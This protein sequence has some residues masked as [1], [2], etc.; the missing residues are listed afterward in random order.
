MEL[1]GIGMSS[2]KDEA[3]FIKNVCQRFS[4]TPT[5]IHDKLT[6]DCVAG[7]FDSPLC[8]GIKSLFRY[9]CLCGPLV[10]PSQQSNHYLFTKLF[11]N[12]IA[13]PK[14]IE[15]LTCALKNYDYSDRCSLVWIGDY[16]AYRC[17]TCGLTP[18]MSL[19][20]ACFTAGNHENHDFNKFK[21]MCGGA[22]DCG[23]PS[24]IRPS[25]NCRFH[26]PDKVANRPC[27]PKELIA[28]LEFLLPDVM[29]ALMFWFWDHCKVEEPALNESEA[30][31]LYFLHRLHACGWVTQQ[32]MVDVMIDPQ[33]YQE[34]MR[35]CACTPA[36]RSYKASVASKP[37]FSLRDDEDDDGAQDLEHTTLLESFLFMIRRFIDAYVDHYSR[38]SST[39]MIT[40]RVRNISPEAAMQLNNRIV[41]ISVQL[42]S[43]VDHAYRMVKEKS[44]HY[45]IVKWMRNMFA[46]SR[47]RLDDRGNMV[48]NCDGVLIQ[49]NAFWPLTSD[50]SNILSHKVVAD[51]LVEDKKFLSLWTD[52]LKFM[53][54]MNCFSM[55]EGSHIEYETMAC[56][57]GLTME[58]EVS[59]SIMWYIWDHYRTPPEKEH[60][61]MYTRACIEALAHQLTYLGRLVASSTQ[62]AHPIRGPLS[63]HLPLS[64]HAACFL[65]LAVF[66]HHADVREL[67]MPFLVPNP[68]VLRRLMEEL[69]NVLLG[70]HE[71][72]IGYW[73]RNGQP[74][75]Q[76]VL[77]YMQSQMCY[78]M[79][80]LDIFLF[81]VCA[82]LMH[83]VYI[84]N[85]LV[86]QSRLL[87]NFCFHRELMALTRPSLMSI[88]VDRQPMA[89]EAWLTNLCWVL[90]LRNNLG[91][92]ETGLIE[93][94]LVCFLAPE[95]R[96]RSDLSYLLPDRCLPQNTDVIDECLQ[97]VATYVAPSCDNMSGSLLS[98]HYSLKPELWHEK[99]DPVFYTLRM[100]SKREQASALEKY[101]LHCR[102]TGGAQNT[103]AFWPPYRLP[104]DLVPDFADLENVLHSRHLHYLLFSLLSLAWNETVPV[105]E[106]CRGKLIVAAFQSVTFDRAKPV[107]NEATAVYVYG[108][109]LMTEES[110]V[111]VIHLLYRAVVAG[112]VIL[113]EGL[114]SNR[115]NVEAEPTMPKFDPIQC[116]EAVMAATNRE[117]ELEAM[118]FVDA[119]SEVEDL[120]E[121]DDDELE[122]AGEE[123]E[124]ANNAFVGEP[125]EVDEPLVVPSSTSSSH[126]STTAIR[127][128][129][130]RRSNAFRVRRPPTIP[131]KWDLSIVACPYPVPQS[132]PTI[133]QHLP[134]WLATSQQTVSVAAL[135]SKFL[136]DG[137]EYSSPVRDESCPMVDSLLSLLVK[138]HARLQWSHMATTTDPQAQQA[139]APSCTSVAAV[140]QDC[141]FL[142]FP[143]SS[144]PQANAASDTSTPIADLTARCMAV[145]NATNTE[146]SAEGGSVISPLARALQADTSSNTPEAKMVK[147]LTEMPP[148]LR[149]FAVAPP[150]Y[151]IPEGEEQ[152]E[153]AEKGT[154]S[155]TRL[156]TTGAS[157]VT[158]NAKPVEC[159]DGVF[160]V[161]RLLDK[162]MEI[163]PDCRTHLKAFLDRAN[164]PFGMHQ[165]TET[166]GEEAESALL[167]SGL[168]SNTKTRAQRKRAASERRKRLLDLMASK[169]RA[170]ADN[171]LKYIDMDKIGDEASENLEAKMECEYDCVI[172]QAIPETPQPMVLL[173]MLCES[174]LMER[175]RNY[176]NL[177]RLSGERM[178]YSRSYLCEDACVPR[179]L[180]IVPPE[181]SRLMDV[182]PNRQVASTPCAA[183]AGSCVASAACRITDTII[184]PPSTLSSTPSCEAS[185]GD[186]LEP[187]A[188]VEDRR[189][190][191]LALPPGIASSL[192][193]LRS[194]ALLQTCGHAVHRECFQRYRLQSMH[195]G[196][197]GVTR[198]LVSCPLC[199]RDVH[200][201]LPLHRNYDPER[202]EF[203][204]PLQLKALPE[205]NP[206]EGA[207]VA[208]TEKTS[209]VAAEVVP[210]AAETS[211]QQPTASLKI[212]GA[213]A[214]WPLPPPPLVSPKRF[215]Q[216]LRERLAALPA[217]PHSFWTNLVGAG[218]DDPHSRYSLMATLFGDC[219]EVSILLRS[220]FEAEL[221]VLMV[222][223]TL[224][225]GVARRC[226]FRELLNYLRHVYRS[227][228]DLLSL[229]DSLALRS[230][231]DSKPI[232]FTNS[233]ILLTFAI[234]NDP[235]DVLMTLLP[236]VW[237]NEEHFLAL[238]SACICLAYARALV[239]LILGQMPTGNSGSYVYSQRTSI[240]C[241]QER[242]KNVRI[243][244]SLSPL[245]GCV[246]QVYTAYRIPS[247]LKSNVL[248]M[249][250]YL[251][252]MVNRTSP[253]GE[254]A[255]SAFQLDTATSSA[256]ST[257]ESVPTDIEIAASLDVVQLN[258]PPQEAG[259][260]LQDHL[261]ARILPTLRLVALS[262]ARWRDSLHI[263][264]DDFS[265]PVVALSLPFVGILANPKKTEPE[266]VGYGFCKGWCLPSVTL[267]GKAGLIITDCQ[268]SGSFVSQFQG[269][270]VREFLALIAF[271]GLGCPDPSTDEDQDDPMLG[272]G[273]LLPFVQLAALRSGLTTHLDGARALDELL[274]RWIGQIT[275][276][277]ALEKVDGKSTDP[278]TAMDG[279]TPT[280]FSPPSSAP[281]PPPP[282]P[283]RHALRPVYPFQPRNLRGSP[284][285]LPQQSASGAG[286]KVT[287]SSWV[288]NLGPMMTIGRQLYPPRLIR[289]PDAFDDLFNNLQVVSCATSRHPFQK[290][291][292]CLICGQLLCDICYPNLSQLLFQH[293]FRCDG[294]VGVA[295]EINTSL[296]HVTLGMSS[297]EWGS[298]YLD[299]YGEEDLDL[300]YAIVLFS[301]P[302]LPLYVLT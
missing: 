18:S 173:V 13:G 123:A 141:A 62:W 254:Q 172:C 199:R 224:Y 159:G 239:G 276:V 48:V 80:D 268:E 287:L 228:S 245:L 142:T 293:A 69:A 226:L 256:S 115:L 227:P 20:G 259:R 33:V 126:D 79:V 97:K 10:P 57:H 236:H 263:H 255:A 161:G 102:Q 32:L 127:G 281:P 215:I 143:A 187:V 275:S 158:Q 64:R 266:K 19:C 233:S 253:K 6:A 85:T 12:L 119:D 216:C 190:W 77:H 284:F 120:D 197:I 211:A 189:W 43:G 217:E 286:S 269:Q 98:G 285:L 111:L 116:T 3:D 30:P 157:G 71:V 68:N 136:R 117:A 240:H 132:T 45:L 7:K 87:Q 212:E 213:S 101:R 178:M 237:P 191:H 125:M 16:F 121:I 28:V 21:S 46:L 150:T 232:T 261:V 208:A 139:A 84:L 248:A 167:P 70:C 179:A 182:P 89:I 90:D 270:L 153:E 149:Y 22:C 9:D 52:I 184:I 74:V 200:F 151:K 260:Q 140:A 156:D 289:P 262:L 210:G 145:L 183:E 252:Q 118:Q 154:K 283:S 174:G 137:T 155:E 300:K 279:S 231:A 26:G 105:D 41:H 17:R 25:G 202:P 1:F 194:G 188:Y 5:D 40:S 160:W 76:S 95:S 193:L 31:M 175:M 114:K 110:L 135:E 44:L 204:S 299:S 221:S 93:K 244:H 206:A 122:M 205:S 38:I 220:Q 148:E 163:S 49:N 86:D 196:G 99:F 297:C 181:L 282:P 91:L 225:Q 107:V 274:Q 243:F 92:S 83:P 15:D 298:I 88:T 113:K 24:V 138:A 53:Q 56:Y 23:D 66:T 272:V 8:R 129:T 2:V 130:L 235:V 195:Q 58:I 280:T 34:L 112:G 128:S 249:A 229:V 234:F 242:M 47:T 265:G 295:L 39:L 186:I 292:L 11:A 106:V 94:E 75:R 169:Q 201:L 100:T 82:T 291:V 29:K 104:T 165:E 59:I 218:E 271:L 55:K 251:E 170:F 146:E 267:W 67:M 250:T 109:P 51:V 166:A 36:C 144:S 278:A 198:W 162:I 131:L 296:V 264:D 152:E 294:F 164:D 241:A 214:P 246:Y 223:P 230:V 134:V 238:G 185:R 203:Q 290:N 65:C 73:I 168:Q 258:A 96:K 14:G 222:Y 81:Q 103:S 54:F 124:R 108:D 72:L 209:D 180:P 4:T 177:P 192:P 288:R 207:D 257:C 176:P 50:L 42:F 219:N 301:P 302:P 277:A 27:P 61:L 147:A 171:F 133:F 63:L 60:C 35:E 37:R 78:S 247:P 273:P